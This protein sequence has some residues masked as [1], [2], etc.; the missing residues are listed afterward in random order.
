MTAD[1]GNSEQMIDPETGGVATYHT[2]AQVP[3][4]LVDNENRSV[5]FRKNGKLCDIAPTIL[6]LM[7]LRRPPEMTGR[8]LIVPQSLKNDAVY[9]SDGN[10]NKDK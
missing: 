2:T 5:R 6:K 7:K 3:F 9:G 4:I 8:S 1:H 10:K